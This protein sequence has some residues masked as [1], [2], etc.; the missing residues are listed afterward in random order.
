MHVSS[1]FHICKLQLLYSSLLMLFVRESIFVVI[2]NLALPIIFRVRTPLIASP[3]P[4]PW[5][6]RWPFRLEL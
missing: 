4:F 2:V 6:R 5:L 3:I 1:K